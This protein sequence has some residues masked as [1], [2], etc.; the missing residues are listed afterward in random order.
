MVNKES[1]RFGQPEVARAK[2][3]KAIGFPWRPKVGDWF[4]DH[5]GFCDLVRTY[6]QTKTIG[7][8]GHAFLPSW[9]DCRQWLGTHGWGH[10]EVISEGR[11]QVMLL[12]THTDGRVQRAT[13]DSDLD[14]LYRIILQLLLNASRE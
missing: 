1:M 4:V 8:N 12:V 3:L 13:G 5:H 6:E 11:G 14:C 7:T 10:P 9:D 2:T